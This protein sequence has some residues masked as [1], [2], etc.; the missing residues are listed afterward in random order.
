MF[1][2]L[3]LLERVVPEFR[4]A[5]SALLLAVGVV[6]LVRWAWER[7]T[8]WLYLGA[9]IS[10]LALPGVLEGSGILRGPGVGT[11]SLGLA[12]LF[13]AAV[14]AASGGGFGWQAWLGAGLVLIGAVSLAVPGL[15][16]LVL[17]LLLVGLGVALVLGGALPGGRWRR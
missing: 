3:L 11:F 5:G 9:L 1:G 13:I 10:G 4:T 14:R 2:A 17:P 6:F 16:S 8:V 12:F 7:G 15:G